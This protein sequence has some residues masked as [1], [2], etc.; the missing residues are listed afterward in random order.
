MVRN[1]RSIDAADDRQAATRRP[2]NFDGVF[3]ADI[4][5][6]DVNDIFRVG[7]TDVDIGL[8]D[9]GLEVGSSVGEVLEQGLM[10]L[11][12]WV[13]V[14][15]NAWVWSQ[16]GRTLGQ[17]SPAKKT[18]WLSTGILFPWVELLSS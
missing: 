3:V 15:H 5:K 16:L 13:E 8:V 4:W 2:L 12:T 7:V 9:G 14:V 11:R 18:W 17:N 6:F 1:H 10:G